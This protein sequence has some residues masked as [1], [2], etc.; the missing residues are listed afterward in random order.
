MPNVP[1][2]FC[3]VRNSVNDQVNELSVDPHNNRF[4]K[5]QC[6]FTVGIYNKAIRILKVIIYLSKHDTTLIS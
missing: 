5:W 3:F 1:R 2:M 6:Y 4:W